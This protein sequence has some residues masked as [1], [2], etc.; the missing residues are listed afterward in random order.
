MNPQFP[1]RL[2]R[3]LLAAR[4]VR[5]PGTLVN[6][7]HWSLFDRLGDGFWSAQIWP[8]RLQASR[9]TRISH[10]YSHSALSDKATKAT[11]PTKKNGFAPVWT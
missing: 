1:H 9:R 2:L 11:L 7:S 3:V 5:D 10:P 6:D 4:L 8:V